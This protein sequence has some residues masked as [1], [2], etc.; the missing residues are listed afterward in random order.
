VNALVCCETGG[1]VFASPLAAHVDIPLAL[2]REA[3]KL[4][5]P[6]ISVIKSPSHVTSSASNGSRKQNIEMGRN[7][8]PRG[9]SVV[10]VDDVLATGETL[11]AV[12]QLLEEAGI[13]AENIIVMVVAEFPFHCGRQLLRQH[14][15]GR[16]KIQSL[17]VFGGA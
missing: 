2:I 14:G 16:A 13:S 10:V 11:C 12:L 6:T 4:P 7:V 15:F 17:L 1:F 8:I 5:P 3:G 9:A